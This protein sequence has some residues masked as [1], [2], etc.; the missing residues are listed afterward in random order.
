VS[1]VACFRR[2]SGSLAL[3]GLAVLAACTEP[4]DCRVEPQRCAIV[5]AAAPAPAVVPQ[6]ALPH[7][8]GPWLPGAKVQEQVA[9]PAPDKP[10]RPAEIV[11]DSPDAAIARGVLVGL[12]GA[13]AAHDMKQLSA[14][15]TK[16][17]VADLTPKL[18]KYAERLW[19]HLDRY[20]KAVDGGRFEIKSEPADTPTRRQVTVTLPDGG[21]L[22]PILEREADGWKVDRF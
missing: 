9:A 22:R 18:D 14:H 11:P 16:R 15:M 4:T 6:A 20:V 5:P 10:A 3:A 19:R 2:A 21:E 1:A 13:A 17:L 8:R 7:P 12:R